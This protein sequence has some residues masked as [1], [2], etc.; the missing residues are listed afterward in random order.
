MEAPTRRARI[1]VCDDSLTVRTQIQKMLR[2]QYDCLP[3]DGGE[4]A[5][6]GALESR[7]D[8]ILSDLMMPGM[9]G[10]E[11]CRRVRAE[12]R[13]R[14]IPFVLLTSKVDEEARFVGLEVGADDYLHKPVR[15]RE[16]H[17]R[18]ASLVKLRRAHQQLELRLQLDEAN[19]SLLTAQQALLHSEK[20]AT[21][22]TLVAG[23]AHEL[24]NPLAFIKGGATSIVALVGDA[25]AATQEAMALLPPAKRERLREELEQALKELLTVAGEVGEGA[26][27]V[28]KI[29]SDL[30]HFSA[31]PTNGR[32]EDV[33]VAEEVERAWTMACMKLPEKPELA[34]RLEGLPDLK[35]APGLLGQVLLSLFLNAIHVLRGKGTVTVAGSAT[36]QELTLKVTDSGP[37]IPME[38]LDRVFDPFFTTKPAG[39]GT[40]L[41]L[42]IAFGIVRSLGGRIEAASPRGEGAT[43]TITLPLARPNDEY[44]YRRA[45]PAPAVT[46]PAPLQPPP[47]PEATPAPAAVTVE[48]PDDQE[49]DLRAYEQ[50]G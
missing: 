2:D 33:R 24:N 19:R 44:N 23:V 29:A 12:A 18:V 42:S 43:F 1:L 14:E 47:A 6:A 22:G 10:Y 9:D 49:I 8:L 46:A 13:L 21:M 20:L 41:G 16:L 26:A 5:L 50:L 30:K 39:E 34:L 4:A 27:R 37:G 3:F 31:R 25:R 45:S 7:P 48:L 32:E 15:E 36:S 40:G 17:A 35:A 11:L 28:Q 38:I